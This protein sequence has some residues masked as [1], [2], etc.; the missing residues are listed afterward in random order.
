MR[1]SI[2]SVEHIPNGTYGKGCRCQACRDELNRKRRIYVANNRERVCANQRKANQKRRGKDRGVPIEIRRGQ[3]LGWRYGITLE[4]YN[5][6]FEQQ[7]RKCAICRNDFG[8][9]IK[10]RPHVDHDHST[11][12]VR[13]LLC[14]GCNNG[15]GSFQENVDKMAAAIAYLQYHSS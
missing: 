11:G 3:W 5:R 1:K 14:H 7:E 12:K 2:R 9:E 13:G 15:L 4:D 10:N 6:M 8:T